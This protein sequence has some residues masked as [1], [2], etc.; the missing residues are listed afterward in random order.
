LEHAIRA[1]KVGRLPYLLLAGLMHWSAVQA[2]PSSVQGLA[3]GSSK[4]LAEQQSPSRRLP[5]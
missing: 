5:S 1:S 4:Q 2:F 3:G